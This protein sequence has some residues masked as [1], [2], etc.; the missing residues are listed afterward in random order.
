MATQLVSSKNDSKNISRQEMSKKGKLGK[1]GGL[2]QAMI[3]GAKIDKEKGKIFLNIGTS[4]ET[5][6]FNISGV[7]FET[8]RSTLFRQPKS[9]LAND[10]FLKK[11]YRSDHKDYFFDRDPDVFKVN[12]L[13]YRSQ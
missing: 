4:R 12:L 3:P 9:P 5:I 6:V 8:Y 10:E 2:L 13:F 1:S 7:T 11:H